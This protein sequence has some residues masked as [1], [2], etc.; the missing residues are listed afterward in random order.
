MLLGSDISASGAPSIFCAIEH[1]NPSPRSEEAPAGAQSVHVTDAAGLWW[2][3]RCP[4]SA[5]W[6][7][8]LGTPV[9]WRGRTNA[10]SSS[11]C[12]AH[13]P[14]DHCGAAPVAHAERQRPV[15][16][17]DAVP[18]RHNA[19]HLRATGLH[20]PAGSSGAQGKD[21]P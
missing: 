19:R 17:E 14:P 13:Q 1:V 8:S 4:A 9:W 6:P 2:A 12:V 11:G 10:R 5:S 15:P 21:E 20:C 16:P 7:G 18:W 3:V